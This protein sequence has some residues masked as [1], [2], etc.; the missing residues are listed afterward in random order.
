[1]MLKQYDKTLDLIRNERAD[2]QRDR[3]RVMA[4]LD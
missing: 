4:E 2:A 1:M 3:D